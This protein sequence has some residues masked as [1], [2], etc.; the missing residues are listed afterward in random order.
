MK[1]SIKAA[2]ESLHSKGPSPRSK[3]R[4]TTKSRHYE[5]SEWSWR[6]DL[7]S[8]SQNNNIWHLKLVAYKGMG[9]GISISLLKRN[10]RNDFSKNRGKGA[11]KSLLHRSTEKK[12]K[13]SESALFSTLEINQR[14]AAVWGAF[15]QEKQQW[16]LQCFHLAY[17]LPHPQPY[18]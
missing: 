5:I 16:A 3:K 1:E 10:S 2:V 14:L 17:S 8:F 12:A 9:I 13:L 7:K 15:S 6:E 4:P 11:P 18:Q